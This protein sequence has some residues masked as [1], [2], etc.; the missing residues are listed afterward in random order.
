MPRRGTEHNPRQDDDMQADFEPDE[1]SNAPTRAYEWRDPE[2]DPDE[3]RP[4]EAQ[5]RSEPEIEREL[6]AVRERRMEMF[7]TQREPLSEESPQPAGYFDN[8]PGGEITELLE[9]EAQLV[10]ERAELYRNEG[11]T[12][13]E[14]Q[15]A[16]EAAAQ[17]ILRTI[18]ENQP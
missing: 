6:A 15:R 1:R 3:T 4:V 13:D 2:L 10:L 7:P 12:L 17:R 5:P 16:E 14:S 9:R 8:A 11:R 18:D